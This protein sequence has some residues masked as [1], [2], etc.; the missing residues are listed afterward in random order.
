MGICIILLSWC[1]AFTFKKIETSF[2]LPFLEICCQIINYPN[3]SQFNRT[4]RRLCAS[5]RTREWEWARNAIKIYLPNI[6]ISH[7]KKIPCVLP[8]DPWPI[9]TRR[10]TVTCSSGDSFCCIFKNVSHSAHHQAHVRSYVYILS[11]H[12]HSE[13]VL[14]ATLSAACRLVG[15]Y[16][17]YASTAQ[18]M[19]NICYV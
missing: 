1:C 10:T 14:T 19:P 6:H 16:T 17:L 7:K 15:R 8:S 18:C 11:V 9:L 4:R 13:L 3:A 5:W 12:L 2:V